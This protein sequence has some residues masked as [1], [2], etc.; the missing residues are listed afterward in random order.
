MN[1]LSLK[2][3]NE[4]TGLKNFMYNRCYDGNL[5]V[6]PACDKKIFY[7]F[8]NS[9]NA[10]MTAGSKKKERSKKKGTSSAA[11]GTHSDKSVNAKK[12]YSLNELSQLQTK[13]LHS[14]I[15]TFQKTLT[16]DDLTKMNSDK[17]QLNLDTIIK[18]LK[19]MRGIDEDFIPSF[20]FF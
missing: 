11:S 4:V 12:S 2:L 7:V 1:D 3:L 20:K 14:K 9:K 10:S 16:S 15:F 18:N 13:E 5:D 17:K 6:E 8:E 19:C